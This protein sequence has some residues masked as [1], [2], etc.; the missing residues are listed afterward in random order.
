MLACSATDEL[1]EVPAGRLEIAPFASAQ[2][3]LAW[4]MKLARSTGW[5]APVVGAET[6]ELVSVPPPPQPAAINAAAAL[7]K[8]AM[9]SDFRGIRPTLPMKV[10][11][12]LTVLAYPKRREML[13]SGGFHG[14]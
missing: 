4:R 9:S 14:A 10:T 13:P 1:S 2:M 3:E 8:V 6:I 5:L 12:R 11:K 7:R